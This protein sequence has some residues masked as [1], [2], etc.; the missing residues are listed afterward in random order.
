MLTNIVVIVV[1]SGGALHEQDRHLQK[2]S[3][4]VKAFAR[5]GAPR[6]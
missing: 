4:R 2:T 1:S 3:G 5:L 6:M